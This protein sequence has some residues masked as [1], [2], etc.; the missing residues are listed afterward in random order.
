MIL[1]CVHT[2][3]INLILTLKKINAH[4]LIT[5]S[6][7]LTRVI[8]VQELYEKNIFGY[9]YI[10]KYYNHSLK[11]KSPYYLFIFFTLAIILA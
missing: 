8:K 3:I 6:T 10:F 7:D 2:F 5:C 1:F 11:K 4:Q 9:H